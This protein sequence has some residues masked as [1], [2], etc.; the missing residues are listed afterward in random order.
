MWLILYSCFDSFLIY[1]KPRCYRPKMSPSRTSDYEPRR[2]VCDILL[3]PRRRSAWLTEV[4]AVIRYF[5]LAYSQTLLFVSHLRCGSLELAQNLYF[6]CYPATLIFSLH[7]GPTTMTH[8]WCP[9]DG[10][11][12]RSRSGG[13]E[14]TVAY[15]AFNQFDNNDRSRIRFNLL[16]PESIRLITIHYTRYILQRRTCTNGQKG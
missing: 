5:G 3:G 15:V 11:T 10:G 13:I 6:S 7:Q 8:A 14:Q 12:S 1:S 2:R 16:T 4:P 9:G